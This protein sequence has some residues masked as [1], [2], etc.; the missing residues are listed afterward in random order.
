MLFI[1]AELYMPASKKLLSGFWPPFNSAEKAKDS[2]RDWIDSSTLLL[3]LLG[4]EGLLPPFL[5]CLRR[6]VF[7]RTLVRC[8]SEVFIRF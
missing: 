2:R 1:T 8:A 7:F 6:W 4:L 3:L 5:A